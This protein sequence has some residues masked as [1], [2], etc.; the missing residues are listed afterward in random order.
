MPK[1]RIGIKKK[2]ET[3]KKKKLKPGRVIKKVNVTDTRFKSKQLLLTEQLQEKNAEMVSYRGLTLGELFKQ[4]GHYN[5]NIRRDAVIGVKELLK[6]NLSLMSKNLMNIIPSVARLIS[7]P[8]NDSA[9]HSQ[10]KLLFSLI[11]KV[12][13]SQMNPHFS[14]FVS[15]ALCGLTHIAKHVKLFALDVVCMLFKVYPGLCVKSVD[16]FNGFKRFV[17]CGKKNI[18]AETVAPTF[19]LFKEVYKPKVENLK[20]ITFEGILNFDEKTCTSINLI[21]QKNPFDFPILGSALVL[22]EV[23]YYD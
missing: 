13:E 12:S 22:R 15:H 10:L 17:S 7:D 3:F 23:Y 19:E 20:E 1:S 16:L 18:K 2:H 11:F 5:L 8:K 9:M 4:M 14:L 6:N 21:E